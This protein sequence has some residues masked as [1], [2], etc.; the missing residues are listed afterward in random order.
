MCFLGG[1]GIKLVIRL[2][3]LA[4]KALDGYKII[5]ILL[6]SSDNKQQLPGQQ[7]QYLQWLSWAL[8]TLIGK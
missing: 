4:F 1:F 7:Q 2:N 3:C 5:K 8:K 6:L